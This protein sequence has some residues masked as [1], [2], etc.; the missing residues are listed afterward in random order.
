ME[1]ANS[2]KPA[3]YCKSTSGTLDVGEKVLLELN[4]EPTR[5]G[6]FKGYLI[7]TIE[8]NPN[9]SQLKLKGVGMKPTL[10]ITESRLDFPSTLPYT[11]NV[12]I[13]FS[14]ENV[15]PFPVEFFFSDFEE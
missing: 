12:E 6:K 10:K 4:F 1:K 14:V 13:T 5:G 2:C 3:F 11:E 8:Q 9:K 7:I 15:S